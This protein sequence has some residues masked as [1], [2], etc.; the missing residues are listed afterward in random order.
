MQMGF[1]YAFMR[2]QK[3]AEGIVREAAGKRTVQARGLTP[4]ETCA[5]YVLEKD[6][7]RECARAVADQAGQCR[8]AVAL[9]GPLFVS[10]NGRVRL[11]EGG[12]ETYLR[13][14]AFLDAQKP[15]LPARKEPAAPE[16]PPN[17]PEE[18]Y[19]L[20]PAGSGENVDTLPRRDRS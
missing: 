15:S 18:P 20:R 6:G 8:L 5:A 9:P 12:D 4:G 10:A 13:A 11:W 16:T 19:T 7:A 14:C 1:G 17:E 3:G 2:G